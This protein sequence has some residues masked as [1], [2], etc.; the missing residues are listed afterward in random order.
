M[1]GI[2]GILNG[3]TD[4]AAKI[5]KGLA[6]LQHRGQESAGIC[7][8]NKD[9]LEHDKDLGLVSYV[10]RE[11]RWGGMRGCRGIGHVRYSTKGS[12]T[13]DNA[14]PMLAS[15]PIGSIAVSYN[16]NLINAN[17]L[18]AKL[19][20]HGFDFVTTTDT[21]I[22]VKTISFHL[23]QENSLVDAVRASMEELSGAY[24][25]LVLSNDEM[26]A[27]R[28]PNGFRPLCLGE[29]GGGFVV[30][31]ETCALKTAEAKF[32][33]EIEN[34]EIVSISDNGIS[35]FQGPKSRRA[36]CIFEFIYVA[37]PDSRI[38]GKNMYGCRYNCGISLAKED[39][40]SGNTG[41]AVPMLNTGGPAGLG[42]GWAKGLQTHTAVVKD[43]Y[44][45]LRTFIK[46][47]QDDR[48]SGV[49]AFSTIDDTLNQEKVFIVDDSIVRGTTK[50]GIVAKLRQ[51]GAREVHVRIASP[52]YRFPCYFGVDT[53][54][55]EELIASS[56]SVK[57][58]E[59]HIGADSLR[60]LS[61]E[62]MYEA[63]GLPREM[64]CD[65]C[66]TNNYPLEIPE[67]T[68][69]TKLSLG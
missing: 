67:E 62:G 50:A 15:S 52:P 56:R 65:G 54:T 49:D 63:I 31:S 37:R 24:S 16:G 12:T 39:Q 20:G 44:D 32:I 40:E 61:L 35:S 9:S 57:E 18:R 17:F 66:L 29:F 51:A 19:A 43:R 42:F 46:P 34:G 8:A 13:K 58:I 21:E 4:V 23:R 14:G 45:P 36:M 68:H 1:C 22:I 2:F 48:S 59:S 7:I 11:G 33:R 26:I 41:I 60:Y 55:K 3:S 64:F 27:V 28:D 47:N 38:Y 10:A 53:A 6:C 30:S 25:L 69:L 5:V